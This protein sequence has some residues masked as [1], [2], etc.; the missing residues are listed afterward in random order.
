[1]NKLFRS[2]AAREAALG[3]LFIL[4][5]VVGVLLW[6]AGP[7]IYSVWLSL[8]DWD[9]L[10]TARFIGF[11]NFAKMVREPLF[12]KSLIVTTYFTIVI[13]PLNLI[14]GFAVA[15]LLNTRVRGIAFYRTIYY[16]PTIVPQV[17]SAI[18]WLWLFNSDF[19]LINA[20]L[21]HL[22][23]PKI[24]WFQDE[25][26]AMPAF[27]IMSVWGSVGAGMIIYL[28]GLQGIPQELYEAADVDGATAW[29]KLW[30]ITIPQMSPIIFF[31]LVMGI[32]GTFQ[33]FT[34]AY[35]ITN[36][37]PNNATL[38]YVLYLYRNAFEW[39][40]MGYAAALAWVL[41]VIILL[42]TL[43]VFKSLGNRVYYEDVV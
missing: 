14:A 40:E 30:H 37:G 9:V 41:F 22:G 13:V 39:F 27:W 19:G 8:T 35:L 4:P 23:L 5:S 21:N 1:M 16:L 33:V 6:Q 26:W 7:M 25:R 31:N 2:L 28:A 15:L 11:A 43:L 32:I 10:T 12:W 17:A 20:F 24:Y 18:L 29:K 36:G 38:F 34:Q 3:Y 42:L